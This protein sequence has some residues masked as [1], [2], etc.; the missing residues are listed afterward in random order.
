MENYFE[1]E[2]TI[3]CDSEKDINASLNPDEM[4]ELEYWL[5][6]KIK[7]GEKFIITFEHIED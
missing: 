2:A 1:I 5:K 4:E 7:S 6:E 3:T